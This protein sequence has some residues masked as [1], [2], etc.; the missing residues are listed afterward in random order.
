MKRAEGKKGA[1]GPGRRPPRIPKSTKTEYRGGAAPTDK[2]L[3]T[4]WAEVIKAK[5]NY[6]CQLFGCGGRLCGGGLQ[7]HHIF[8]IGWR[9]TRIDIENGL[10][11]C[12]SHHL[13]YIHHDTT[14]A[15]MDI[16]EV[17][18]QDRYDRLDAKHREE[19]KW[20]A[21]DRHRI[22]AELKVMLE[23]LGK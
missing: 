18:G 20:Y 1:L 17:I 23:E 4:V 10:S 19:T 11:V 22:Y 21:G 8:K 12:K 15:A 3:H 13:G 6:E 2:Q 9:A 14:K 16:L 7:A 5:A